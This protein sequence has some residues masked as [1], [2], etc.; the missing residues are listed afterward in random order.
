MI[1]LFAG[2][3]IVLI[4]FAFAY[5]PVYPGLSYFILMYSLIIGGYP[6]LWLIIKGLSQ[7]FR[8]TDVLNQYLYG[9]TLLLVFTTLGYF[10][11]VRFKPKYSY[12][13]SNSSINMVFVVSASIFIFSV[14]M[15]V[16]QNGFVLMDVTR[17]GYQQKNIAN[18]G[19]G[20][21]RVFYTWSCFTIVA[22]AMYKKVAVLKVFILALLL[23]SCIYIINGGG[24][25]PAL[26]PLAI[27]LV[28]LWLNGKIRIF[29]LIFAFCTLLLLVML[30]HFLRYSSTGSFDLSTLFLLE[31]VL[32]TFSPGDAFNRIVL[33]SEEYGFRLDAVGGNVYAFVPRF[34][35]PDKPL[36]PMNATGI[37]THE[38]LQYPSGLSIS[39][40]ILGEA[41][42]FGGYLG[43]CLIGFGVGLV[44]V[45][46][47][48]NLLQRNSILQIFPI[49][50]TFQFFPLLRE[51][52]GVV[53]KNFV[54]FFVYIIVVFFVVLSMKI[55][56]NKKFVLSKIS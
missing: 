48:N 4:R 43:I 23:G 39:P 51:G 46:T 50:F 26:T 40:T 3:L 42:L 5:R 36:F 17:N 49:A 30:G 34:I 32:Q 21:I 12:Y 14:I 10:L 24:R 44:I 33:Y 15:Y 53:M 20:L 6:F 41:Y 45:A 55:L 2:I 7:D 37:Y 35:W 8:D 11:G 56:L 19:S 52:F 47:W 18:A 22:I 16:A 31:R 29:K 54:F 28:H 25:G 9:A 13:I 38:I 27:V 1:Y